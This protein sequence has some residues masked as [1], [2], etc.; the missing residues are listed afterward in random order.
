MEELPFMASENIMMDAVKRGGDRQ[1]LH[2]LIRTHSVAAGKRVKEDGEANDL[3][4]RIAADPAFGMTKEEIEKNLDPKNYTGRSASQVTEF[5]EEYVK[6]AISKYM[7]EINTEAE[8][9]V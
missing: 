6:P 2:E 3:I 4:D 5:I 7:S 9:K 1:E 8:L